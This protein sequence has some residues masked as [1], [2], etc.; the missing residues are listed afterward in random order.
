[1]LSLLALALCIPDSFSRVCSAN[2][3]QLLASSSAP[4]VIKRPGEPACTEAYGA[5]AMQNQAAPSPQ[6]ISPHHQDAETQP[7]LVISSSI[8]LALPGW[9]QILWPHAYAYTPCGFQWRVS[10]LA[11]ETTKI[12]RH[13]QE[14]LHLPAVAGG[15]AHEMGFGFINPLPGRV[16]PPGRGSKA[17]VVLVLSATFRARQGVQHTQHRLQQLHAGS[18]WIAGNCLRYLTGLTLWNS[19]P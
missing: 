17:L 12:I 15:R 1:M 14:W 6:S 5:K 4:M 18:W 2:R 16:S 3:L 11:I 13:E 10:M 8:H 7:K 19:R 9:L